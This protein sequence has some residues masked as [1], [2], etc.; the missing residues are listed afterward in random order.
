MAECGI[1]R[2][3]KSCNCS[4]KQCDRKGVCCECI[5][6]HWSNKELPACFFPDDVERTYDRS[7]KKFLETCK[8]TG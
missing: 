8:K 2:N 4:Y 1:P 5:R 7:L 6:Y 3:K